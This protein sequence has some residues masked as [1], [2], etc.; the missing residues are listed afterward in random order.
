MRSSEFYKTQFKESEKHEM[1]KT[2]VEIGAGKVLLTFC[3]LS[4]IIILCFKLM[5]KIP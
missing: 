2:F 3:L 1:S 5:Y 4:V